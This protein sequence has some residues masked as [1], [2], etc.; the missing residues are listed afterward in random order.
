MS[1]NSEAAS[2][3]LS[4]WPS[5]SRV[6]I[7]PEGQPVVATSPSPYCDSSSRSRRG[8]LAKTESSEAREPIRKRL[9]MPVLLR[10]S[11]VM[12]V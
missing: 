6:W 9:C 3:A 1:R 8:H 2:T 12:C 4:Y 7:S 11:S 10:A 5:R